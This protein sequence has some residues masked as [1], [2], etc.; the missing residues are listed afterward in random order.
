MTIKMPAQAAQ[1]LETLERAGYE[2]YIVGGC[3]RDSLMGREPLDYDITTS[4]LP[5][6]VLECFAGERI[7]PTGIKHGT[8]TVVLD[9]MP[10]EITTYRADGEYS[11]HRRPDSVAFSRELRDDLCR[12]DFTVNAMA[13]NPARGIVDMY[14][15]RRDLDAHLIRCVGTP[16]RRFDEDALRMLR[17]VRFAATLNFDIDAPTL[18]ALRAHAADIDYVARERIFVE[19]NK[20]AQAAHPRRALLAG[21]VLAA[22][23]LGAY[24]QDM[25]GLDRGARLMERMPCDA[26]L[27]WAALLLPLGAAGAGE[28][29]LGLR[30]PNA[31]IE[32]VRAGI[33]GCGREFVPERASVLRALNALGEQGMDDALALKRACCEEDVGESGG[34]HGGEN[35]GERSGDASVLDEVQALKDRLIAQ[36]ECYLLRQLMIDGNVLR[37]MGYAG[38][39]IGAE[40]N[41]LLDRVMD[42]SLPNERKALESAAMGDM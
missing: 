41:A 1:V 19:L 17:A 24:E 34:E 9:G 38:K 33:G 12:R 11:D 21:G 10:L 16:E 37:G 32:R 14:G 42:G 6:E 7:I 8:V 25:A 18:E 26:A 40:L 13:Y 35:G 15:G 39:G 27:R 4:A 2:A 23:A 29:L 22:R 30:A 20:T 36:G 5:D 3:V 28:V 31:L